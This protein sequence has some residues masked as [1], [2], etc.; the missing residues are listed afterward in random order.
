MVM[1]LQGM[2][3][4]EILTSGLFRKCRSREME[5]QE[6]YGYRGRKVSSKVNSDRMRRDL[7]DRLIPFLLQFLSVGM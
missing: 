3:T 7:L 6:D 4:K 2:S 1:W 5:Y